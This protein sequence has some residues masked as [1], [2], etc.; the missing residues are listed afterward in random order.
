MRRYFSVSFALLVLALAPQPLGAQATQDWRIQSR[1]SQ[2]PAPG[3]S[4]AVQPAGSDDR[5]QAAADAAIKSLQ[6]QGY[7]IDD[8]SD[9]VL[10]V[11]VDKATPPQQ[12]RP[13]FGIAAQG[14]TGRQ[15]RVELEA[16]LK[17]NNRSDD[18]APRLGVQFFLFKRGQAPM[19]S[20][21]VSAPHGARDSALQIAEMAELA[22]RNFGL[23]TDKLVTP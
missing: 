21:N 20:A 23:E 6:A 15:T 13:D 14:G 2:A 19:W 7:V 9:L 5:S 11:H 16:Q 22:M 8:D 12:D 18:R 10:R 1:A 4:I 17:S 3:A